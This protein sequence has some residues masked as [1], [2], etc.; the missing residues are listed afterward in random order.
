MIEFLPFFS[1]GKSLSLNYL[2]TKTKKYGV[3]VLLVQNEGMKIYKI[4]TLRKKTYQ[5]DIN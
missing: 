3:S 2:K 4:G 1:L 5:L